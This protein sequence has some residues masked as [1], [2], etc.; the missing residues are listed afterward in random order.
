LL[1]SFVVLCLS[2]AGSS[3]RADLSLG[4]SNGLTGWNLPDNGVTTQGDPGTVTL[5]G[6][7][8]IITESVF[9]AETDLTRTF[10]I[11]TAATFLQ[12]TLVSVA[13]DS[14]L[15]DN[16]ANRY[17][18][19]A[20]GASLLNPNTLLPLVPTVNPTTD[21]FYTRDVVDG[22]TQGQA[23][24][25]VTALSAAGALAVVSVDIS[26]LGLAGQPAEVL[27]RLTGGTDPSSS[28]TVTLSDVTVTGA[29]AVPEPST[30]LLACLGMVCLA[31]G[32]RLLQSG[33]HTGDGATM[34]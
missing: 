15:A 5:S 6:S 33:R 22:V 25:G 20:F 24:S 4:F 1:Q 17:F 2:T 28:T 34:T 13:P 8:A 26:S 11:P 23:A 9:A 30:F 32:R 10:T 18:P 27:F 3:A 14:T 7:Q 19:D 29:I 21:S 16:L 31:S 12:F